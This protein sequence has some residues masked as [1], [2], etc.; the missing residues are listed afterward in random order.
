MIS[1]CRLNLS[2][3][4]RRISDFLKT[5]KR[6][7]LKLVPGLVLFAMVESVANAQIKIATVDLSRVFTN[8]WKTKQADAALQDM[9]AEM[10]KSDKE[11][12]DSRLKAV[13]SYQKLLADANNQVLSSE[14][15]DK[16]K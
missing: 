16:R 4:M 12:I 5:M 8:Y 9:K 2:W 3:R 15:R 1:R 7:L 11:L 6:L 14:E 10:T 13:E